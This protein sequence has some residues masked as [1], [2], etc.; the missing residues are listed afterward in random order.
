M[1]TFY[2]LLVLLFEYNKVIKKRVFYIYL[3]HSSTRSDLNPGTQQIILQITR[4]SRMTT[5]TEVTEHYAQ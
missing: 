2:I 1:Y 5:L 4:N 3:K